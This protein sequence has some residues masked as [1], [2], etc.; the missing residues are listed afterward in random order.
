[1]KENIDDKKEENEQ[2]EE[3]EIN[4]NNEKEEDNQN[5]S[6]DAKENKEENKIE[7]I[8]L[9]ELTEQNNEFDENIFFNHY[10]LAQR[11]MEVE[12]VITGK[13][14][15]YIMSREFLYSYFEDKK[16]YKVAKNETYQQILGRVKQFMNSNDDNFNKTFL[17]NIKT[18]MEILGKEKSETII[19]PVLSK[20][21][22]DRI[23]TKIYFLKFLKSFIEHLY[24][25][26]EE[27]IELIKHN[28]LNIFEE[29]Y[30]IKFS[31]NKNKMIGNKNNI[32]TE[33]QQKE[34]NSLLFERFIQIAK[35]LIKT[36]N[37]DYIYN[38][39][40]ELGKQS[41]EEKNIIS[42]NFISKKVL[43]IKLITNLSSD[44]GEKFTKE[45]IL[46][47][48][49]ENIQTDNNE[50]K[51]EICSSFIT[52]IKSL[53]IEF[54]GD[55]VLDSLQKISEDKC[56]NIRKKCIEVLYKIIYELKDKYK[57]ENNEYEK[58]ENYISKIIKMI[59]KFIDDK[60]K[61]VRMFLIEKIGEI[62]KPLNKNELPEKLFDFYVKTI[63]EYYEYEDSSENK[64]KLNYYFA[65]NFPAVL[66]YYTS[67]RWEKLKN[68]YILL[69]NDNDT[70][71]RGSIINSFYEV[72]KI[73][74]KEKTKNELL[75]L[76][77]KFLEYKDFTYTKIL[78]EKNLPKI[79]I[80]LDNE[81]REKYNNN[82]NIGYNNIVTKDTHLI[83]KLNQNKKIHYIKNILNYYKLYDNETIYKDIL[84]KCL[85]FTFDKIYKVR[86][87]SS[88][89]I[90]EII[91]YLYK[92][93]YKKDK[94]IK[95]IETYAFNKKVQQRVNFIKFCRTILFADNILYNER[96]KEILFT[97]ANKELNFNVLIA[98]AKTLKKIILKENSVCGKETSIHYLCKKIDLKES[99]SINNIFKNV[100]LMKNEKLEIVGNIPEGEIFISDN[101]FLKE[102]FG[103][104]I[105]KKINGNENIIKINNENDDNKYIN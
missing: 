87:A 100:K 74:G 56:L 51:E 64:K 2:E 97:I 47:N 38:M 46:P 18:Y 34:Y 20:I 17:D 57:K 31:T 11:V 67:E 16:N 77:D 95:L 94:I 48:L 78:A 32:G 99:V 30:R 36:E 104:E 4:I 81:I 14:F 9:Y 12:P 7:E 82:E 37:K 80:N 52:L 62:I 71:V 40:L 43:L 27:G 88:K 15:P 75:P 1:M 33:E 60:K 72:S 44:F 61:K 24:N 91:L 84:P 5:N 26:G 55:Y 83:N 13:A 53:N 63:E 49:S 29:L 85:F 22:E 101:E 19:I 59:E 65:Y 23:A 39:I 69:C 54:I 86:T 58:A 25:L 70:N 93:E 8:K 41:K 45:Y 35:I 3:E 103:V 73:L 50:I 89:V 79:L 90:G 21:V 92:N 76:Y 6:D 98:L 66:L 28:I 96:L 42:E 105:N 102:E 10:Y 68:V